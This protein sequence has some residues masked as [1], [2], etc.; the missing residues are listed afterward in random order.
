MPTEVLMPRLS[1]DVEEGVVVT[2]FVEP[3]STVAEGDL[4]AE[5]QVEKVSQEVY[6]P[7]GGQVLDL[8]VEP[9]GTVTQGGVI[10]LLGA[11]GDA[12][13][14]R[15]AAAPPAAVTT[16][17][18]PP[19][20]PATFSA[21]PAASGAAA[22]AS[23]AARRLARELGIDLSR[24][25]G[26]GPG[27]RIVED[28][29]KA[30]AAKAVS[31]AP[32]APLSPMR[33]V[34]ADR[35]RGWLA[36]TAQLTLTAE[37]DVTLLDEVLERMRGKASYVDAV[38][39]ACATSLRDHP[40]LGSRWIDGHVVE[41]TSIDIGVAVA[42]D[43]GLV[44][45]VIR[46]ADGKS[47]D[48]VHRAVAE[49]AQRGHAGDLTAADMQG[50]VFSVTNLGAYGVDAFTPLLDPPQT[51]ILGMGRARP[52]PAVVD[53]TVVPRVLMV[54]SL[55]VDHQVIDGAPGA[56]FLADVARRLEDPS[57]LLETLAVSV[58]DPSRDGA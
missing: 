40:R 4:L 28:D 5:I 55:T 3:G 53:G 43:E 38:V 44:V 19:A 29:V 46:G 12:P 20:P 34:I 22:P 49:L 24:V 27:G 51:A 21:V 33:R 48:G 15:P 30:V 42:L 25:P 16:A 8:R 1:E 11:P 54:L 35:L 41:P 26:T 6:A 45:P 2:W 23:P 18:P 52:R 39:L 32:G 10:A 58:T 57:T 17:V 14:P 9:G 47:L 56:A 31:A 7:S 36:A 50:A 37:V 13:P